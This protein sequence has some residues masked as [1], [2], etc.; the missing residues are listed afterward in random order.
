MNAARHSKEP[1]HAAHVSR[2]GEVVWLCTEPARHRPG[3]ESP[4]ELPAGAAPTRAQER[5]AEREQAKRRRE[6]SRERVAFAADLLTKRLPKTDST[7]LV[8]TQF[9]AAAGSAQARTA[10]ALLGI[11]PVEGGYG[12]DYRAA[13]ERHASASTAN[14][15]RSALALALAAGRS[16]CAT[17]DPGG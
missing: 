5:T 2:S 10:C 7:A 3:G 15:D 11:E 1:C 4:V 9:L 8:V 14:R 16:P 13:L 17:E 12:S 6:A